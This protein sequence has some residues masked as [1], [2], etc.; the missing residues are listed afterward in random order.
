M[1]A[2]TFSAPSISTPLRINRP[3]LALFAGAVPTTS[4]VPRRCVRTSLGANCPVRQIGVPFT[5]SAGQP[6]ATMTS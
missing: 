5:I 3:G 4:I 2:C 6:A 1:P